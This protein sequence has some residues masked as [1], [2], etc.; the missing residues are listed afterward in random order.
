MRKNIIKLAVGILLSGC[1]PILGT[2]SP[3]P[4]SPAPVVVSGNG[5]TLYALEM[6]IGPF[7]NMISTNNNQVM[8]SWPST[9]TH[10]SLVTTTNN[11][12]L[13][14]TPWVAPAEPMQDDG[15]NKFI[16]V[17]PRAGVT[18]YRLEAKR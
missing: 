7:L 10:F 2:Q 4:D 8:I 15:T 1:L 14:K 9:A 3:A 12:G 18:Y 17:S 5:W 11:P 6:P 16:I 13:V